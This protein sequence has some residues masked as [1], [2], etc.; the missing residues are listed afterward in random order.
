MALGDVVQPYV[1]RGQPVTS[2]LIREN[3]DPS[4]LRRTDACAAYAAEPAAEGDDGAAEQVGGVGDVG[5]TA[6]SVLGDEGCRGDVEVNLEVIDSPEAA[7]RARFRG[8]PTFLFDGRDPFANDDQP[9]GLSC[10]VYDTE[11][12]LQGTPT[13]TQL[14]ALLIPRPVP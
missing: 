6:R 7:E 14:R 3:I 5:Q 11:E 12:G 9:F 1:Q 4:P 2:H 13:E 8:S 10:R